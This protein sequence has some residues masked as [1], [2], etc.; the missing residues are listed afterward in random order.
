MLAQERPENPVMI[1]KL[2]EEHP[3]ETRRRRDH[4]VDHVPHG[5]GLL[6]APRDFRG[7]PKPPVDAYT[8]VRDGAGPVVF[9]PGAQGGR[10]TLYL[11]AGKLVGPARRTGTEV[12]EADAG[13]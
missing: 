5:G 11:L 10:A 1:H 8:R 6:E 2:L 3:V 9:E 12:C 13:I 7:G 4:H